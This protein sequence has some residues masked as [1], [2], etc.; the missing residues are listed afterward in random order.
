MV[1]G[2]LS[3]SGSLVNGFSMK[4]SLIIKQY[5]FQRTTWKK[6]MKEDLFW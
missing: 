2:Y 6:N 5:G 3:K 1:E 4:D